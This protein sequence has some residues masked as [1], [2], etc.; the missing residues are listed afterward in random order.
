[1]RGKFGSSLS[2]SDAHDLLDRGLS[3]AFFFLSSSAIFLFS[4]LMILLIFSLSFCLVPSQSSSEDQP[5]CIGDESSTG[6]GW[7]IS[8]L[9][10]GG[11]CTGCLGTDNVFEVVDRPEGADRLAVEVVVVA[12]GHVDTTVEGVE[13]P[14]SNFLLFCD[15]LLLFL[16]YLFSLT[17]VKRLEFL[18]SWLCFFSSS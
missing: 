17:G 2:K 9:L 8:H 11:L 18:F 12:V 15:L 13:C 16:P 10:Y 4:F 5:E 3:S 6:V 7:Q 1:M 14:M